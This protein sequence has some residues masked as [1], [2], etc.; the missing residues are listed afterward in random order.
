MDRTVAALFV[1]SC[2]V[3]SGVSYAQTG[4]KLLKLEGSVPMPDVQGR[5]DHLAIDTDG[6][7]L[8]VAA[9]GNNSFEVI[10]LKSG[11]TGA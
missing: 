10:D 11:Q 5:I 9:L 8:F 3:L 6:R 4:D 1:I 2:G 7:R